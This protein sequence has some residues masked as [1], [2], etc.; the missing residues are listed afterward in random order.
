MLPL[1]VGCS[2]QQQLVR[3]QN[4]DMAPVM[5]STAQP[6]MYQNVSVMHGGHGGTMTY[7]GSHC[8][9]CQSGGSG[10]MMYGDATCPDGYMYSDGYCPDPN[11]KCKKCK[12]NGC[13]SCLRNLYG[14]HHFYR[15]K[16]PPYQHKGPQQLVYPPANSPAAVVQYPYYT[17]KGPSDF[18]LKTSF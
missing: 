10:Q 1:A 7:A 9:D 6:G 4:P 3:S 13:L 14:H 16:E 11:G 18:F 12:G 2:S 17:H 5:A 8:P 15:Y